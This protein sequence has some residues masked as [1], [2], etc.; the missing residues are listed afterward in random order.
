MDLYPV[1]GFP[2]EISGSGERHVD[3]STGPFKLSLLRLSGLLLPW[4]CV[5]ITDFELVLGT[6]CSYGGARRYRTRC[7][8][9]FGSPLGV[10][11]LDTNSC[12][13][14]K[15]LKIDINRLGSLR[16]ALDR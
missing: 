4:H 5:Y 6:G 8:V 16:V 11:M 9:G 3:Q 14:R 1:V 10:A 7:S 12:T 15:S 2:N 13:L